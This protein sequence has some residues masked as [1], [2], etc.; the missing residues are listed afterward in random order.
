MFS[1]SENLEN[2]F[3]YQ[4]K[5]LSLN[6]AKFFRSYATLNVKTY[7]KTDLKHGVIMLGNMYL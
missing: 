5:K 1:N 6:N 4:L 2:G 7:Y 3:Q